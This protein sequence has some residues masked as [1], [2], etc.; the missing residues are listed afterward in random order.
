[1]ELANLII[2]VAVS[3]NLIIIL[4]TSAIFTWKDNQS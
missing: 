1:M 3:L 4:V 2:K